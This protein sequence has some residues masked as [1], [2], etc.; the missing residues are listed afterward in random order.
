MYLKYLS[1]K[2]IVNDESFLEYSITGS[3]DLK[4]VPRRDDVYWSGGITPRVLNSI[5]DDNTGYLQLSTP[6][7]REKEHR[8]LL[9]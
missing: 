5:T 7:S 8:Y 6:Y 1:S 2:F 3:H 9:N 4:Q